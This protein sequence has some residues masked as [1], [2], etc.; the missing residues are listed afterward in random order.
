MND[1]NLRDSPIKCPKCGATSENFKTTWIIPKKL[2]PELLPTPEEI[3]RIPEELNEV[4]LAQ[5]QGKQVDV[6]MVTCGG[7]GHHIQPPTP[8]VIDNEKAN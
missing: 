4:Q 6:V 2:P 1:E 5:L 7:C 8:H 3:E